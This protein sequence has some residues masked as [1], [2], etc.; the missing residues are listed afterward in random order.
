MVTISRLVTP[1]I[2]LPPNTPI[3]LIGTCLTLNFRGVGQASLLSIPG[4]G[5]F[6]E[7]V[8]LDSTAGAAITQGFSGVVGT[9]ILFID[10]AHQVRVEVAGPNAIRVRNTAAAP[11]AGRLSLIW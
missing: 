1:P 6:I 11:R 5:G 3:Q 8:G 4:A 9:K 7:W 2:V 10:F